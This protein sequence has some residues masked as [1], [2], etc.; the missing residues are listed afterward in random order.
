METTQSISVNKGQNVGMASKSLLT[1]N[2]LDRDDIENILETALA[3]EEVSTR[4]VKKVPA[5]RG[6]TVVNL[7]YEPSTRTRTSFEL[8]AKRLSADVI[9]VATSSSA[10]AKGES[11]KDT[12]KTL[13]AMGVDAVVVRHSCA[14]APLLISKWVEASVINAGD[15]AHEHPTQALLDMYT[16]RKHKHRVEGLN[17]ILVGDIA[18]SRVAR[19]NILAMT[20]MGAKVTV[21]AP[22]TLIPVD[23]EKLGCEVSYDL[24]KEI[25][26][27]DVIYL[28]RMQKERQT[29]QFLPSIREYAIRYSLTR[30]RLARAKEDVVVMHPGPM[31]RGVEIASEAADAVEDIIAEQVTSGI[32]VRMAVL[33]LL[34]GG[35]QIA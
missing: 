10:V 13:Q 16:I 17:I 2:Q 21:V 7:F 19:S 26:Q 32:S 35:A 5:L 18:H 11:L 6:K 25:T 33:Y 27:A 8:A 3:F 20:K 34:L 9:N 28:L 29:E 15:G 23:I 4:D 30:D 12:A 14:G 24:D 22:P 31:N 1:I